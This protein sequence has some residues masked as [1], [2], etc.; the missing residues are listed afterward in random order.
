MTGADGRAREA[1]GAE[2]LRRAMRGHAASVAVVTIEG[3]GDG[4][5]PGGF[6]VSTFTCAS[7]HP[8]LVSFY[9]ARRSRSLAG[10]LASRRFGVNVLA[11]A[12]RALADRFAAADTDRFAAVHWRSGSSGPP[13][14]QGAALYIGCDLADTLQVGDHTLIIGRVLEYE[15]FAGAPLLRYDGGYRRIEH[16]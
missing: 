7:L 1:T 16:R 5:R 12:Q 2:E 10:L 15:R 9:A 13:L 11:D 8:P 4:S 3:A 14:I 6:T